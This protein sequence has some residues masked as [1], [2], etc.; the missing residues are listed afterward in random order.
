MQNNTTNLFDERGRRIPFEGMR[1]FSEVSLSYYKINQP[2]I[3]FE[4]ILS[5]SKQYTDIDAR[6]FLEERLQEIGLKSK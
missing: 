1:V 6:G 3:Q 2:E 4:K 5:N